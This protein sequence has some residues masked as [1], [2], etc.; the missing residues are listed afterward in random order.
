ML[1]ASSLDRSPGRV[2]VLDVA[3]DFTIDLFIE[4]INITSG[5]RV[6]QEQW[7]SE[8]QRGGVR[9][10]SAAARLSLRRCHIYGNKCA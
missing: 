8:S 7:W 6:D 3:E 1:D 9:L 4:G 10:A 5:F 2:Y